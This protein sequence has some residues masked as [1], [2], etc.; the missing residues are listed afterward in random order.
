MVARINDKEWLG[1]SPHWRLARSLRGSI[2]FLRRLF[3]RRH[4]RNR[5]YRQGRKSTGAGVH[6]QGHGGEQISPCGAAAHR[7]HEV[8]RIGAVV[9]ACVDESRRSAR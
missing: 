9:N 3:L 5:R 7:P 2:E 4:L 8:G 1:V 6:F